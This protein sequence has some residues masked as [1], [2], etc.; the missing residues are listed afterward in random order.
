MTI[1]SGQPPTG[2]LRPGRPRSALPPAPRLHPPRQHSP[3]PR[4]E[5]EDPAEEYQAAA[6]DRVRRRRRNENKFFFDRRLIPPGWDYEYKRVKCYGQEDTDHQVNLRENGWT[7][8][9]ASRHPELMPIGHEGPI[10]KDGM[11]LMERP[12]ELTQ[13]ARAEDYQ[14]AVDPVNALREMLGQAPPGQ[15]TRQHPSVEKIARV[16]KTYVPLTAEDI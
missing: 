8:V 10:V 16:K 2:R 5:P 14:A 3:R 9:P 4:P 7:P 11:M 12:L 15:F 1:E 13:E 6:T